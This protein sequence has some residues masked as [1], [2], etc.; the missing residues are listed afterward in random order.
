MP[1]IWAA[2]ARGGAAF[3]GSAATGK[4]Q[5]RVL[6]CAFILSARP[7]PDKEGLVMK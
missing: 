7:R 5:V 4:I 6:G 3:F 1:A 2:A